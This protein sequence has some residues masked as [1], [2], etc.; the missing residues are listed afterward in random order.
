[1]TSKAKL[2]LLLFLATFLFS[3]A[4]QSALAEACPKGQ[5]LDGTGTCVDCDEMGMIWD[6]SKQSCICGNCRKL[7]NGTCKWC[8]EDGL[9][10]DANG[11]C[12]DNP[13]VQ[14]SIKQKEKPSDSVPEKCP[15]GQEVHEKRCVSCEQLGRVWD[16]KKGIC[17]CEP[18]TR[19]VNGKCRWCYEDDMACGDDG[20]C[21]KT[22]ISHDKTSTTQGGDQRD[23]GAIPGGDGRVIVDD[24]SRIWDQNQ[25]QVIN[26]RRISD[27]LII[28]ELSP[29]IERILIPIVIESSSSSS[30]STFQSPDQISRIK[31]RI[32]NDLENAKRNINKINQYNNN[33]RLDIKNLDRQI[34]KIKSRPY[35]TPAQK[36]SLERLI[37]I[38]DSRDKCKRELDERNKRVRSDHRKLISRKN[39]V[40]RNRKQKTFNENAEHK[41]KQD[42]FN[43]EVEHKRNQQRFNEQAE[44]RRKQEEMNRQKERERLEKAENERKQQE[45][46][47][48]KEEQRRKAQEEESRIPR[49]PTPPSPSS[50]C[51]NGIRENSSAWTRLN[52]TQKNEMLRRKASF[53]AWNRDHPGQF[54]HYPP[55]ML[56]MFCQ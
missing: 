37:K 11:K 7:A 45:M 3:G 38:R 41:R 40:D 23:T 9:E 36:Q 8:Y 43:Q 35:L 18:C 12:V 31:S 22:V 27:G 49:Q 42:R 47:R 51:V 34:N 21:L 39:E 15:P 55:Q 20:Q 5:I 4:L 53:D 33:N 56:E 50:D 6:D 28:K 30:T 52:Q 10:C 48:K 19:E 54:K 2:F 44:H 13:V 16:E 26:D 32:D 24:F 25:D 14:G 1:M 46:N 29:V 17:V